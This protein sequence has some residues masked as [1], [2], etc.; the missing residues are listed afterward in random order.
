M[1]KNN[2]KNVKYTDSINFRCL[3]HLRE[4]SLDLSL[5]HTG[6]EH[7]KPYHVFSGVREEYIIHF[8]LD[9]AGF[10]SVNGNTWTLT[11][12]QMF[13]IYPGDAVTYGADETTPWTYAWIGFK[14]MRADTILRQCG[15]SQNQRVLPFPNEDLIRNCI[16]DMLDHKALSFSD[17]LYRESCLMRILSVLAAFQEERATLETKKKYGY[18]TSTYTELA[19]GYIRGMYMHGITVGDIAE[20][21]GISRAHLNQSFQKELGL[22]AQK[23]LIDF[24]M[25][26]A[27]NYLAST[28]LSVKEISN[29]VGYEDQLTFSKAF[30]KKFGM[31][32]LNYRTHTDKM[33]KFDEKQI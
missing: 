13:L 7:C 21:V 12:G 32:P 15:F 1:E 9:G 31:S 29:M 4:T 30:K 8:V 22:S 24:R 18:S 14:G 6:R 11:P 3:E 33:D 28:A 5:V 27:A 20:N 23:F 17:N 26:R 10:F 19:I 2:M 16:G 25:H